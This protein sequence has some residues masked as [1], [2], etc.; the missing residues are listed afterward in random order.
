MHGSITRFRFS[1]RTAQLYAVRCGEQPRS[2]SLKASH[3]ALRAF[4]EV[5]N[6]SRRQA[7]GLCVLTI[8]GRSYRIRLHV[9]ACYPVN[10]Y[11]L[12]IGPERTLDGEDR[13]G[14]L[15]HEGKGDSCPLAYRHFY[16]S[17]SFLSVPL[18][19]AVPSLPAGINKD[20]SDPAWD[21]IE[22]WNI[23]PLSGITCPPLWGGVALVPLFFS[24]STRG[25]R[26]TADKHS[27]MREIG[28]SGCGT[29]FE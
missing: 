28:E 16:R 17:V 11:L 24:R 10:S 12:R 4:C 9:S 7:R 18:R 19:G 21:R 8:S 6:P 20:E 22:A 5:P 26:F 27:G 15:R 2:D 13:S 14:T 3:F 23:A 1:H 25:G 29:S